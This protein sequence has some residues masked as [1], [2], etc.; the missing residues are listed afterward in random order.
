MYQ[1]YNSL[2]IYR[3]YDGIGQSKEVNQTTHLTPEICVDRHRGRS[4]VTE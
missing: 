1:Q 3:S 2:L 4:H